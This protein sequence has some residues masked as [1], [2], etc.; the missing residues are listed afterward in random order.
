MRVRTFATSMAFMAVCLSAYAAGADGWASMNG[1]TTGG[2]GGTVVTVDNATD[3]IYYVQGTQQAAYIIYVSGHIDLGGSNIRVRGN[4]TIIG[5]P[6]SRIT[7]NFKCYR[8]EESNN[9]FQF[10]NM[11]NAAKAGDGDCISI[12][13]ASNIW[14]DH[15]T[16]TDA[17][18]GAVDIKNGADYVT[19]SWCKYQY[20]FNS[21]HNFCNLVGHSDSNGSTDLGHLRVT[22][23][24]NWYSTL[25][26][27]RMPSVRFGKAHVY[28]SYFN[29]PGNRYCIRTRLY[30]ECLV[31]NNYFKD[32]QNPWERYVTSAGGDPGLLYASGN[33]F[34]NVTWYVGSDS[35]SVLIDGTD[36]V[37]VPPYAYAPD[38]AALVPAI[39]QWG[40]GV[41]GREGS[42]PHW[43]SGTY[44]DFDTSGLVD[45]QD[46]AVFAGYW[47]ATD[48]NA[49]ADF[50]ENGIVDM[51]EL[52]M[53]AANWMNLSPDVTA[54]DKPATFRVL[55]QDGQAV[56]A[57]TENTEEDLAGYSVYRTTTWG[58]DY[59][60]LN[61]TPLTQAGYIDTD[62]VN[63]TM[64]YYRVTA[65]DTSGN[66]SDVS[67]DGCAQPAAGAANLT[68]QED[69]PGFCGVQGI[70]DYGKHT[71]FTGAGFLDVTNSAGTGVSWTINIAEAGTYTLRWRYANGSGDRPGR[72]LINGTEA[73]ASISFPGTG[74]WNSWADRSVDYTFGTGVYTIR[75]EGTTGESLANIDYL[76]VKGNAPEPA[77]CP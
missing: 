39:V 4:K 48:N 58:T 30:A 35:S 62:V 44:G 51:V 29:S 24:H 55:G 36:T 6:G 31:E 10:L 69:A 68:L 73:A 57:W 75:L 66:E 8:S 40:A 2:T 16:F 70:I 65:V 5:L 60:R 61:E 67:L 64:Y 18:D 17:G 13:G 34:D 47:L 7:G 11:D 52:G 37:F 71:G 26:H 72:L 46:F 20:T 59:V 33:I 22:F 14:V 42:P 28:N 15:C 74:A 63:G 77:V 38:P 43:L 50:D 45:M 27:E 12:D 23:H 41:E 9:I 3:L 25:C 19:V 1:G 21:G 32:V 53:F 56:L 49:D 76:N 54:P